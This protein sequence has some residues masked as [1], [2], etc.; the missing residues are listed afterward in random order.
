MAAAASASARHHRS[1]NALPRPSSSRTDGMRSATAAHSAPGSAATT[2]TPA[3][4]FGDSLA[5][6][7]AIAYAGYILAIRRARDAADAAASA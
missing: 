3:G 2:A 7:A 1:A 4:L 5:I 6:G